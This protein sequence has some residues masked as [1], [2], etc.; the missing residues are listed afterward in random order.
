MLR[1]LGYILPLLICFYSAKGQSK[2]AIFIGLQPA[3][4][5]EPDYEKNEFDINVL[6]IVF[7]SSI[8]KKG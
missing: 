6:P 7:Q 2:R 5:V 8:N 1:K 4:T 3:I